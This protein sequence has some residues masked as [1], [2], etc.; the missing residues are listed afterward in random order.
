MKPLA[1]WASNGQTCVEYPDPTILKNAMSSKL[2]VP[3][4][5]PDFFLQG[6]LSHGR[7]MVHWFLS[8]KV[9]LDP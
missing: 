4:P 5:V 3:S 9:I 1:I 6:E 8:P 2:A 7:R